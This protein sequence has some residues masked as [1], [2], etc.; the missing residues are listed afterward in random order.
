[1]ESGAALHLHSQ[2]RRHASSSS[3]LGVTFRATARRMITRKVRTFSPRSRKPRE[4]ALI[5]EA[6][7]SCS[8]V[9]PRSVRKYG[10]ARRKYGGGRGKCGGG[11]V[12]AAEGAA[13]A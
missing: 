11:A 6:S 3:P 10:G 2:R 1:M 7:A 4:V 12:S 13:S 9:Q 5:S 8:C